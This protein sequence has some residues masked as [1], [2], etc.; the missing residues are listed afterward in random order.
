MTLP[1]DYKKEDFKKINKLFN[2]LKDE[3]YSINR[4]DDILEE[5][6]A[7]ASRKLYDFINA[8]VEE[9]VVDKNKIN[10][11]FKIKDSEKY[12]VER[13]NVFGSLRDLLMKTIIICST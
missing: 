1:E 2:K 12:Y 4:V 13:I 7:I 9:V 5:I 10:F 6:D 3:K 11:N 8:E